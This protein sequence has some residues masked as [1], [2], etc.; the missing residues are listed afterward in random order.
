[1][2]SQ[3]EAL[4]RAPALDR[5]VRI[6]PH[7]GRCVSCRRVM[8]L[9]KK[10]RDACTVTVRLYRPRNWLAHRYILGMRGRQEHHPS[11]LHSTTNP[12]ACMAARFHISLEA[13]NSPSHHR[14]SVALHL[15]CAP[16]T[17]PASPLPLLTPLRPP[18]PPTR[19]RC[20]S[21]SAAGPAARP[22]TRRCLAPRAQ[23]PLLPPGPRAPPASRR[24]GAA[25]GRAPQGD[26]CDV[27]PRGWC[28]GSVWGEGEFESRKTSHFESSTA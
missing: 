9:R 14:A 22:P 17:P 21:F 2:S 15:L 19:S 27:G 23:P 1:M 13:N 6:V 28:C 8:A 5:N 3:H 16:V 7:L 25:R 24:P 4:Q 18:R 20:C 26:G 12:L 10:G 11:G